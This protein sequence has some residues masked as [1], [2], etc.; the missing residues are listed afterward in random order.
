MIKLAT[1][2]NFTKQKRRT[3]F[4]PYVSDNP[5]TRG[6]AINC[7]KENKDPRKPAKSNKNLHMKL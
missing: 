2:I 6:E 3:G 4:R 1:N 5:P 7:R